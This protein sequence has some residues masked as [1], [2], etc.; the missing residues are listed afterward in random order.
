MH[1]GVADPFG[2]FTVTVR[3]ANGLKIPGAP[4]SVDFSGCPEFFPSAVQPYPG[5][6]MSC[7]TRT[8]SAIADGN[9]VASFVIVG[10]VL[11]RSTATTTACAEVRAGESNVVLKQVKVASYDLDGV[12]GVDSHDVSLWSCDR[13]FFLL[14]PPQNTRSDYGHNGSSF[15]DLSDLN[16]LNG[17]YF[18]QA[19]T[20]TG[21][22]CDAAPTT[23]PTV[24]AADGGLNIAWNECV[25]G[26]GT[27]LAS[28]ACN[29]N[30]GTHILSC[31]MIAPTGID[32][33]TSFEADVLVVGGDASAPL[34]DWWKFGSGFCR[35]SAGL[36]ASEDATGFC[37]DPFGAGGSIG[38]GMYIPHNAP[39]GGRIRVIRSTTPGCGAA[40][41]PGEEYEL[42]RLTIP[43]SK[44][45]GTGACSG[46]DRPVEV[47]F[48][49]VKLIQGGGCTEPTGPEM[50]AVTPDVLLDRPA[51]SN[52]VYWQSTFT[53]V[54]SEPS[55]VQL[56]LE[57]W[58]ANPQDELVVEFVLPTSA[59]ASL[60]L[61]DLSGRRLA[62]RVM[63]G[64]APGRHRAQLVAAGELEA[65][66]YFV[67]LRQGAMSR[68][69]K[70]SVLR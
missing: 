6:S 56:S 5:L 13:C 50:A 61:F 59:P 57:R 38:W 45:T 20:E 34:P 46:C 36:S 18:S 7:A 10:S 16:M 62:S 3:D 25:S 51:T 29:S 19:S 11:H 26:G 39:Y 27:S 53:G 66:I 23:R 54:E 37:P 44:T 15:L 65:G 52:H 14:C 17:R 32:A 64:M 8:V 33:L 22:R 67:R 49:S 43:N 42:F 24:T 35:T 47:T 60:E 58:G 40:L 30:S 1:D 4:V 41:T 2:L 55:A 21:P 69:L 63:Q 48:R 70:A 28:F 68:L 31:S 12:N 9:G